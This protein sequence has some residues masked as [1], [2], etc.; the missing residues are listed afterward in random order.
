MYAQSILS[1]IYSHMRTIVLGE[2]WM[3]DL[4]CGVILITMPLFF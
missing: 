2:S 3:N 4:S 1:N